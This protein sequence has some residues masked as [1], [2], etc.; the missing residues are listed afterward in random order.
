MSRLSI[1][2]CAAHIRTHLGASSGGDRGS[3]L[4][5]GLSVI[6]L[7]NSAGNF[8]VNQHEWKWLQGAVASIGFVTGERFVNLPSDFKSIVAI[9]TAGLTTDFELVTL[10]RII[11]LLKNTAG[12]TLFYEAAIEH[13]FPTSGGGPP[14]PRLSIWPTPDATDANALNIYYRRGW[15]EMT[16]DNDLLTIPE[17]MED[18]YLEVL[19]ACAA[20]WTEHEEG[21]RAQRLAVVIES[22]DWKGAVKRDAQVQP[23]YGVLHNGMAESANWYGDWRDLPVP[24]PS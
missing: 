13:L 11:K 2:R 19:R 7:V 16:S 9:D 21:S 15:M 1:E 4:P 3:G 12:A 10:G 14:V 24:G 17:W 23:D 22:P 20:G 18:T 5:D 8:L 6:E